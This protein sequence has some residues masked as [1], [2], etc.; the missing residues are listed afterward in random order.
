M[1]NS[2][3]KPIFWDLDAEKLD[4]KKNAHSIIERVLEWGDSEQVHWMMKTYSKEEIIERVKASRQLSQKSANF[5]ANY[6][7]IPKDEVKCLNK[8]FREIHRSIWPY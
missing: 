2:I 7:K 1:R 3:L 5:W 8:S 4:I 6:Y